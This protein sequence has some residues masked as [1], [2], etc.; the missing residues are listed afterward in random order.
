MPATRK[1]SRKHQFQSG[2]RKRTEW[3]ARPA[4]AAAV[5]AAAAAAGDGGHG[6]GGDGDSVDSLAD[7]PYNLRDRMCLVQIFAQTSDG[8]NAS[9]DAFTDRTV[10]RSDSYQGQEKVRG[11]HSCWH[12][13]KNGLICQEKERTRVC[14]CC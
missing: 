5:A 12:W 1:R 10:A 4:A 11:N 7:F 2:N 6:R 3:T 13:G 9:I 14:S 8:F